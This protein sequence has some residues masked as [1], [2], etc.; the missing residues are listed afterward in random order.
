MQVQGSYTWEK[1]DHQEVSLEFQTITTIGIL[2][3]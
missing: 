1:D 3:M 2:N